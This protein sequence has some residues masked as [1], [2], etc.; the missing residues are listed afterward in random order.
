MMKRSVLSLAIIGSL[1]F[2]PAVAQAQVCAG[3]IIISALITSA[4]KKRELTE[5]EAM[6]CGIPILSE[7]DKDKKDGKAKG[8]KIRKAKADATPKAQ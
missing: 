5:K 3:I 4:T 7:D 8:K 2:A 1:A 6:T